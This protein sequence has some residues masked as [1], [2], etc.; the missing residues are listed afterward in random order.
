ML[1]KTIRVNKEKMHLNKVDW[2]I[3]YSKEIHGTSNF[4]YTLGLL[5]LHELQQ[6]LRVMS[7]LCKKSYFLAWYIW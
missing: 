4:F 5:A 6:G 2:N 3:E 7:G 1:R